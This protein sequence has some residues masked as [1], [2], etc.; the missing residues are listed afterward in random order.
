M[1]LHR[2]ERAWMIFGV[3]ML[4]VFLG[5]IT[6]AAVAEGINPPSLVQS[7]DPTKVSQTP[8]FDN[9]GLRKVGAE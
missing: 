5:V 8:P 4:L 9:P 7:I 1:H 2:S 6:F 3:A